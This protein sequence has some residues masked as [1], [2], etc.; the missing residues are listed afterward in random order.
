MDLELV[1]SV[2]PH[3]NLVARIETVSRTVNEDDFG[4]FGRILAYAFIFGIQ[5]LHKDNI[6]MTANG[7]QVVD[8]EQV[9]SELILPNQ[10]LMLALS[11]LTRAS[12]ALHLIGAELLGDLNRDQAGSFLSGFVE[13]CAVLYQHR[14]ALFSIVEEARAKFIDLPIRVFFRKTKDYVDCMA[15]MISIV[16]QMPEESAQMKRGDVPF[17]FSRLADNS[18]RY[19][20]DPDWTEEVV[21]CPREMVQY[22]DY[23]RQ[24]PSKLLS[25]H[26]L[27]QRWA[28]GTLYLARKLTSLH[29]I[30]IT[31]NDASLTWIQDSALEVRVPN[32]KVR[33]KLSAL[34]PPFP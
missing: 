32:L 3:E 18:V 21:N 14:D 30:D 15:G 5:D 10:T 19:Y 20:V 13:Q 31:W 22:V 6:C 33:A 1:S 4:Q 28:T 12:A 2:S 29:G 7:L 26:P 16:D 23:C 11:H 9:F 27:K 24:D 25:E 17:F 8:V 34:A